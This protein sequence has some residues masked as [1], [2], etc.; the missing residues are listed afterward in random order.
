MKKTIKTVLLIA[1]FAFFISSF[2]I[3]NPEIGKWSLLIGLVV[4]IIGMIKH[5][6]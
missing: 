6:Q 5:K 3:T 4:G 2:F 1:A